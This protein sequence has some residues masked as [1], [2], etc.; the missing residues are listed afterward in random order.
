MPFGSP[1][2]IAYSYLPMGEWGSWQFSSLRTAVVACLNQTFCFQAFFPSDSCLLL[3][4]K[5]STVLAFFASSLRIRFSPT[6]PHSSAW[7]CE[8]EL[9]KKISLGRTFIFIMWRGICPESNDACE[10]RGI[11]MV[12]L[13]PSTLMNQFIYCHLC[14]FCDATANPVDGIE[15]ANQTSLFSNKNA[16]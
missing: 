8:Q 7:K 11:L 6:S 12:T 15:W 2:W 16:N 4:L 9:R 10:M 14:F 13:I 5:W 3:V 1:I